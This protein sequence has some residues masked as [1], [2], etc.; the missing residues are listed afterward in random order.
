ME[1]VLGTCGRRRPM[2]SQHSICFREPP[3]I[4]TTDTNTVLY[5]TLRYAEPSDDEHP[6][7]KLLDAE[8][9]RETRTNVG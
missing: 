6:F 1:K 4:K 3:P 8:L 7:L 9:R 5:S 2:L